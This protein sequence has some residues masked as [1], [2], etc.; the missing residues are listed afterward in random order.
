LL[1]E[2]VDPRPLAVVAKSLTSWRSTA[3][4]SHDS[5][6]TLA[7]ADHELAVCVNPGTSTTVT[8]AF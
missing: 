1:E 7:T 3:R 2:C 5:A 8:D 4:T 6:T